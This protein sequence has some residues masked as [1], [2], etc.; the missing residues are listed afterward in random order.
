MECILYNDSIFSKT[1][2][3]RSVNRDLQI[4]E[5][6]GLALSL[7]LDYR[8][9]GLFPVGVGTW[10]MHAIKYFYVAL[11]SNIFQGL[12]APSSSG[13]KKS[14]AFAVSMLPL[15]VASPSNI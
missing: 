6:L 4:D 1:N 8:T 10:I 3:T 5:V 9:S 11:Y 12:V 14:V 7:F 15:H 13:G 2:I